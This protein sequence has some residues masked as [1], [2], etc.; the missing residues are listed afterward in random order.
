M[1]VFL[2][3]HGLSFSFPQ[4]GSFMLLTMVDWLRGHRAYHLGLLLLGR[5]WGSLPAGHAAFDWWH[6]Q[7]RGKPAQGAVHETRGEDYLVVCGLP[8]PVCRGG[9]CAGRVDRDLHDARAARRAV[10]EWDGGD[11]VLVGDHG[12]PGS[13][14]VCDSQAG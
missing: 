9:G 13:P 12:G 6:W 1:V 10:C 14:G 4:C 3:H 2:L 11:R 8:A 5:Y 7:R